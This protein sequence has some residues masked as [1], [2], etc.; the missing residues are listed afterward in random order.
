MEPIRHYPELLVLALVAGGLALLFATYLIFKVMRQDPGNEAI[1]QIGKA[2]QEG[3]MAFLSREYR[4]ML[5]M[6]EQLELQVRRQVEERQGG[7]V[8]ATI[9][10]PVPEEYR[11]AVA[12]YFRRLSKGRP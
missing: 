7:Q 12:E 5:S 10:Q 6:L 2:I 9:A 1:Q 4:K 8:R 3:A 11:E